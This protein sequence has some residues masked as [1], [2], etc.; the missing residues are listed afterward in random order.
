MLYDAVVRIKLPGNTPD[1]AKA[2][3]ARALP[4]WP[5]EVT[6]IELAP[7]QPPPITGTANI[8]MPI[9]AAKGR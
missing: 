6:G 8:T 5:H 7:E 4:H 9:M 1:D 3:L 2:R